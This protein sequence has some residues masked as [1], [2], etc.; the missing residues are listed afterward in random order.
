MAELRVALVG[1]GMAG[2]D[3]HAPLLRQVDGLRVTHVVTGDPERAAAAKEENPGAR[4]LPTVEEIWALS[5][6][7]DVVVLASPTNVHAQ[8]AREALRRDLAVVVDKPMAVT[9]A[10][11]R[12]LAELAEAR[13]VLLTVFQN[14][15]WSSDHLTTRAVLS[16]GVL[17]ELVRYEARYERWR[18]VPKDRWREHSTSADGGGV[19]MDLQSHLV[20][21]ALDLFGP[22]E[23]VYAELAAITTVGDDVSFVV[24]KHLS[25]LT[26]HLG[27][28]SLAGAPG[29]RTRLLGRDGTYL[30][31]DIDG[32]PTAYAAWTDADD[33]H[34]G[35]LV[36][37]EESQPVPRAPGESAD[38]YVGVRDA[39][40][41]G[42]PPPV[43]AAEAVAVIEVLDAARRSA[44]ENVVVRIEPPV[45]EPPD[46]EPPVT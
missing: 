37:G 43:P 35:W 14:R 44:A 39:L 20:D 11:A 27:A 3:F 24:I 28:T 45:L 9:A 4:V 25:G 34:R 1:Y 38:F 19:L 41:A 13:G 8:Q 16:S 21:G 23:S 18:P 15:R 40:V 22:A 33:E 29:P 2:R 32:D 5:G 46:I 7:I 31:A 30:V 6:Q 12:E 36:L 17:G 26:S 42:E 10:D